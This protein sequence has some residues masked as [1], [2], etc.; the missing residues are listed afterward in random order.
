MLSIRP[1]I[2]KISPESDP[3]SPRSKCSRL[4]GYVTSVQCKTGFMSTRRVIASHVHTDVVA[5][6]NRWYDSKK[7]APQWV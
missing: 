3:Q 5:A 7:R 4:P 6:R 2:A 1:T